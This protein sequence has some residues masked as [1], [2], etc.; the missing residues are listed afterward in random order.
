VCCSPAAYALPRW[1]LPWKTSCCYYTYPYTRAPICGT[2]IPNCVYT[3]RVSA[4]EKSTPFHLIAHPWKVSL[5]RAVAFY[6]PLVGCLLVR[7]FGSNSIGCGVENIIVMRRHYMLQFGK[8]CM[9]ITTDY[10]GGSAYTLVPVI[11][12]VG[13]IY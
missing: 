12:R 5:L 4:L 3:S 6:F 8:C 7:S 9:S 2:Y 1:E 13:R 10:L 11:V